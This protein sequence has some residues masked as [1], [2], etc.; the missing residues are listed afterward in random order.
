MLLLIIV[1]V[2]GVEKSYADPA[3]NMSEA[4]SGVTQLSTGVL[5]S[6]TIS[7][8]VGYIIPTEKSEPTGIA[9]GPDG[10]L[11]FTE[12]SWTRSGKSQLPELL[13]S[14]LFLLV[15]VLRLE[16]RQALTATS[17]LLN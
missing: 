14:M 8:I 16:L 5:S 12:S 1:L 3:V 10:N 4:S 17:G 6:W 7:S 13:Q 11:W 15:K 2:A 9:A